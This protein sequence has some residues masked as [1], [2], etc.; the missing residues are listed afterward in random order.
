MSLIY[1]VGRYDTLPW[2]P[3]CDVTECGQR[4]P[5]LSFFGRRKPQLI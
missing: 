3:H 4:N 1:E 2:I 5:R